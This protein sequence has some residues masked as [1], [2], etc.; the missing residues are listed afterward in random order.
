[1]TSRTLKSLQGR[2]AS[3]TEHENSVA[4]V[5]DGANLVA[6]NPGCLPHTR[7]LR[8]GKG[9]A[10]LRRS[11]AFPLPTPWRLRNS[12]PHFHTRAWCS[13]IPQ[14]WLSTSHLPFQTHTLGDRGL[15]PWEDGR[16]RAKAAAL[17]EEPKRQRQWVSL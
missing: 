8:V 2:R 17:T 15:L 14:T 11:L 5:G 7:T 16:N 10:N 3:H 6:A 13:L 9:L 12:M 4:L 1:M